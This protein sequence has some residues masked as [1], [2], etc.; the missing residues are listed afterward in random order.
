MAVD[1]EVLHKFIWSPG[2][3]LETLNKPQFLSNF[4]QFAQS[5]GWSEKD[6][7]EWGNNFGTFCSENR[8]FDPGPERNILLGEYCE[9]Y[10]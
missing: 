5:Q 10:G 6:L 1:D 4:K 8:T 7:Q 2:N 9:W 3:S